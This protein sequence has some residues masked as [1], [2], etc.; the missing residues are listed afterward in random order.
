MTISKR[1]DSL[2]CCK[3]YTEFQKLCFRETVLTLTSSMC[4]KLSVP[5]CITN[6]YFPCFCSELHRKILNRALNTG[7]L[8]L[9]VQCCLKCNLILARATSIGL[10]TRLKSSHRP[11]LKEKRGGGVEKKNHV[12][13]I[14]IF[15]QKGEY[16]LHK[17]L[18]DTMS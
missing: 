13:W 17:R 9:N 11:Y 7:Y 6:C 14:I 1:T 16:M 4:Y 15:S 3:R 2:S 10:Q 12:F 5:F 18:A 8:S